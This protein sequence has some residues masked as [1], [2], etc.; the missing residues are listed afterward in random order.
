MPFCRP[1]LTRVAENYVFLRRKIPRTPD[2]GILTT[3]SKNIFICSQDTSAANAQASQL[4]A[5][6]MAEYPDLWP[7]S[8]RGLMAHSAEWVGAMNMTLRT[9]GQKISHLRRYGYGVPQSEFL[10][11]SFSNRPCVIIQDYLQPFAESSAAKST[12]IVFNDMNH[13]A[14]PW[15]E[16]KLWEIYDKQVRLRVTLSYFIEPS[17]SERPPRTKYSYASHELR[18]KLNRPNEPEEIFLARI[19]DELQI[20]ELND[21]VSDTIEIHEIDTQDKWLLGPQSRDRGSLISDI[22]QGTGAELAKQ[23]LVAVVPQIGWWKFRK[24]FPNNDKGRFNEQVRYSLILSLI[25]EEEID[26]YTPI[27]IKAGIEI[28]T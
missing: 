14:L 1:G 18:F 9:K 5:R 28:L 7:E 8:I 26:L 15:P 19:N 13:Y 10:L 4:A 22:W 23:N 16:E 3:D 21:E 12:G 27:A 25:T 11:N 24:S 6:L 20:N 2:T 17:P